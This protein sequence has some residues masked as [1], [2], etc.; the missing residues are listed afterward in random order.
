MILFLLLP[1]AL[2]SSASVGQFRR[3]GTRRG[4]VNPSPDFASDS[5]EGNGG[6]VRGYNKTLL[7][8]RT[9]WNHCKFQ[10]L[11]NFL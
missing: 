2:A 11:L 5:V 8:V 9:C 3:I 4:W 7:N 1:Q 6:D 10:Q